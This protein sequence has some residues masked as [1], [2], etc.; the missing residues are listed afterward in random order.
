MEIMLTIAI[1]I[2]LVALGVTISQGNER[3]RAAIQSVH[4]QLQGWTEQDIRLKREKLAREVCVPDTKQWLQDSAARVIGKQLPVLSVEHWN[5]G[6]NTALIA[7]CQDG[8]RLVF[9][10][11]KRRL[12]LEALRRPDSKI[13]KADPGP[14]G[15]QPK[16]AAH[17]ELSVVNAGMF[18]DLEAQLVWRELTG[19]VL[20]GGRLWMYVVEDYK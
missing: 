16:K 1:L 19:Q 3:Q 17:F 2:A 18:F 5:K 8:T 11:L 7:V 9:T 13:S 6:S 10:P 14:L 20:P 4:E 15:S 12:F